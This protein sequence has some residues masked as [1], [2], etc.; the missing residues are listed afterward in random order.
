MAL[1]YLSNLCIEQEAT[2]SKNEDVSLYC[3][4]HTN[5]K[6][7][8]SGVSHRFFFAHNGGHQVSRESYRKGSINKFL[9]TL[10]G[11]LL[12]RTASS[13]ILT[14][15]RLV[16]WKKK[17][18]GLEEYICS[19]WTRIQ[20]THNVSYCSVSFCPSQRS[21]HTQMQCHQHLWWFSAVIFREARPAKRVPG[22]RKR[23]VQSDS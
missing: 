4:P 9:T 6:N 15:Q 13:M 20:V 19:R 2:S 1:Q 10:T 11:L 5:L 22:R 8:R 7:E 14:F 18:I 17:T 12:T 3:N 16:C 21:H 23:F